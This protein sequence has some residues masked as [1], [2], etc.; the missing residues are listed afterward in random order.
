MSKGIIKLLQL[1]FKLDIYDLNYNIS[2]EEA[3]ILSFDGLPR[4]GML[5]RIMVFFRKMFKSFRD[6]DKT[7]MKEI[8]PN[9]PLFFAFSKNQHD[10][11]FPIASKFGYCNYLG[12]S[13]YGDFRFSLRSA[14]MLSFFYFPLVLCKYFRA[15]DYHKC[16]FQYF[17]E[18]FWLTY[19]Y[20]LQCCR[21][22][23]YFKPS[24][25][26]V[27]N[28]HL[29]Y[30]R[31]FVLAAK[32]ANIKTVYLQHASVLKKFPRLFFDYAFLDGYDSLN[33][34]ADN[35]FSSTIIFLIGFPKFDKSC[36]FHNKK[37]IVENVGICIGT[38]EDVSEIENL[39]KKLKSESEN[40][41][42][43]I[44][45]HPGDQKIHLWKNLADTS[46]FSYSNSKEESSFDFLQKVDVIISG[47]SNILLEA[48]LMN[49]YPI[50]YEFS[51]VKIKDMYGFVKNNLV[52]K[53]LKNSKDLILTLNRIA[54]N[55][56][57]V[58]DR[59]KYYNAVIN[60][61][62]DGNS[63]ELV[64]QLLNAISADNKTLDMWKRITNPTGLEVYQL[65][66]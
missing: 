38:L 30:A 56:P 16:S 32:Q 11:I 58:R 8:V 4:K 37:P 31:A 9:R 65:K 20:Y 17:F 27:S 63:L 66:S 48:A 40:F 44:R 54:T 2:S 22:L 36:K 59:A 1:S 53:P 45:P 33:K 5:I 51:S 61:E 26:V 6:S 19:G 21:T 34:Y 3:N 39:C 23:N 18:Y 12:I 28:D 7:K 35:G 13:K 29:M 62:Y 15:K 50:Y 43:C 46:N 10:A 14:Y 60:T 47:E 57:F 25:V 55:R 42:F 41:N 24:M 49:V 52:D 64:V